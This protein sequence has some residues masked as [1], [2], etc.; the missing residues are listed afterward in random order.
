MSNHDNS[1]EFT[2]QE[3]YSKHKERQ[4]LNDPCYQERTQFYQCMDDTS[5]NKEKCAVHTEN[6]RICKTFWKYVRNDR[7]SKGLRPILPLPEER[8]K[9]K[10]EYLSKRPKH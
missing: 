1:K 3:R 10:R 5:F 8:E 9:I 4:I 7:A 6:Y 2:T